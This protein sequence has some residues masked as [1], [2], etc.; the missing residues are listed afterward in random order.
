MRYDQEWLSFEASRLL[1]ADGTIKLPQGMDRQ[2]RDLAIEQGPLM[3]ILAMCEGLKRSLTSQLT[4]RHMVLDEAIRMAIGIQGQLSGVD[5]VIQSLVEMLQ[6]PAVPEE[7]PNFD[8]MAKD[9]RSRP[10]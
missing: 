3:Y 5:L 6:K 8:F 10:T 1:Q 7:Q 2:L 9:G 4:S